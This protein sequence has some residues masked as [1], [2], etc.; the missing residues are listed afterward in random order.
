MVG[1]PEEEHGFMVLL[2]DVQSDVKLAL[3]Y[4]LQLDQ[5]IDRVAQ[6]SLERD[7]A[8]DRRIDLHSSTLMS[9]MTDEIS[10]MK[11]E[12]TGKMD[13]GFAAVMQE[14]RTL[15]ERIRRP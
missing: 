15:T 3:D 2:E 10:A 7:Q 1:V 14:L 13:Q 6:E 12:L 9:V 4:Y 5:K 8:L 11:N